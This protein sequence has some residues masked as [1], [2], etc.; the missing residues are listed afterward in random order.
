MRKLRSRKK[1]SAKAI[2]QK[3]KAINYF[4]LHNYMEKSVS[5]VTRRCKEKKKAALSSKYKPIIR[6]L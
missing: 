6:S 5:C 1:F 4:L 3:F 2:G